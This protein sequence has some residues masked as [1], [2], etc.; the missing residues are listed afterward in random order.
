MALV[1]RDEAF[2]ILKILKKT[3]D[4]VLGTQLI[5]TAGSIGERWGTLM[6][7]TPLTQTKQLVRSLR[8]ST[9][10]EQA[11]IQRPVDTTAPTLDWNAYTGTYQS[12]DGYLPVTLCSTQ[13]AS[14]YCQ[15]VVSD[16]AKLNNST[17]LA[18]G[19]YSAYPAVGPHI[20]AFNTSPEMSSTSRS[21]RSF[22][23]GTARIQVRSR[24]SKLAQRAAGWSSRWIRRSARS[25]ASH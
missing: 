8:T 16:F 17:T 9:N 13:S 5:Q 4:N 3:L 22:R 15:D 23:T 20:S 19:F 10:S 2:A 7:E 25:K 18:A 11:A 24:R 1:N 12:D 6:H 21:L 14:V